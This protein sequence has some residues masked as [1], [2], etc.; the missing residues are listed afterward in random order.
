[1]ARHLERKGFSPRA[2]FSALDALEADLR[3]DD[4]SAF[5]L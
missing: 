3:S 2:I 1:V 4:Q 5:E